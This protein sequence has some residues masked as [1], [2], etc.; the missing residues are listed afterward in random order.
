MTHIT[1]IVSLKYY[2]LAIIPDLGSSQFARLIAHFV[3]HPCSINSLILPKLLYKG[4]D[5]H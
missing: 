5:L 4:Q 1:L 2:L 3:D